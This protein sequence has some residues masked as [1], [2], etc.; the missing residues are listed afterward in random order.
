M[1]T[2]AP[3][4]DPPAQAPV[5]W[6]RRL[7]PL[8]FAALLVGYVL[9]RID[10]PSFWRHLRAVSYP[11]LGGFMLVFIVLLLGADALAT[12]YVYRHAVAPV[13]WRDLVLLRGASYLPSALN[14]HLGQ[15]WL[16]YVLSRV[17]RVP[18]ARVAGA[19]LVVYATWAGCVLALGC[20]AIVASGYDLGWLALPIGAGVLYLALLAIKPAALARNRVLAPLF[21]AGIGGHFVA[22]AVRLPHLCVLFCG[23]WLPFWFFGVHVPL[24]AALRVVPIIM[25]AVTLP[26]TPQGFGTRDVLAATFFESYVVTEGASHGERLAAVAAATTTQGVLIAL[27]ALGI[28]TL[29]MPHATK[30]LR[31]AEEQA[32][33]ERPA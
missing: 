1:S 24:G 25:V 14:H 33:A 23:T 16:T 7:V 32:A 26:L 30:R 2:A 22:M 20:I 6:W 19:T 9:A 29:L 17:C 13:S 3:S 21:E 5:S 27:I 8:G 4:A 15:A 31:A 18:L 12:R 10:W 28:G 11:A